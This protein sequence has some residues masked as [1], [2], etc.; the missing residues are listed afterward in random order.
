MGSFEEVAAI[1]LGVLIADVLRWLVQRRFN[2]E[3][4]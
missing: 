4:E 2:K 1:I 3:T